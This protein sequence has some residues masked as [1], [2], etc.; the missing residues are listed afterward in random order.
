MKTLITQAIQ[1][2]RQLRLIYNNKSR[3]VEPHVLG[4]TENQRDALLCW[5]VSPPTLGTEHWQ[6]FELDKISGLRMIDM[7]IEQPEEGRQPPMK[8]FVSTYITL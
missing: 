2:R 8:N 6:V 4:V 5:Q 1:Q 7:P 3:T